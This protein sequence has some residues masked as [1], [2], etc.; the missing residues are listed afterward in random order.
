MAR[1]VRPLLNQRSQGPGVFTLAAPTPG[2]R[3]VR[4]Y[5]A[6]SPDS[7]FRISIGKGFSSG[8]SSRFQ[9]WA[10]IP[11]GTVRTV[12]I[13]LPAGTRYSIL[14]IPTPKT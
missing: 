8:C 5:I 7:R 6:C 10:D 12:T 13:T 1:T 14:V 4:A 9:N 11:F 2:I 3:S